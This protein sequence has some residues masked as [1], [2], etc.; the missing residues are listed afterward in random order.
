MSGTLNIIGPNGQL[1]LVEDAALATREQSDY[2]QAVQDGD[3]YSWSS[4]TYDP[5]AAATILG[6][7]NNSAT[8]NLHI[9][10]IHFQSDTA[11]QIV[12]HAATGATMAGTAVVGVNLNRNSGNVAPATAKADET[13][14]GGA[15]AS[16][17]DRLY[18]GRLAA[19]GN[20]IIRVGGVI[21]L[22]NDHM[23]GIDLTTAATAANATIIGYFKDR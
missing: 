11:S 14:N 13:G 1:A 10:E 8:R 15:A 3:A 9:Q 5:D 17:V 21:W 23:I 7:E 19:D 12:V 6:V 16:Y 4:L 22:P 2:L 18:T 20:I